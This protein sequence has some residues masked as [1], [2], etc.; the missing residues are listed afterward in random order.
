MTSFGREGDVRVEVT[1][2][3]DLMFP[4]VPYLSPLRGDCVG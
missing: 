1:S 3:M 2:V 4:L